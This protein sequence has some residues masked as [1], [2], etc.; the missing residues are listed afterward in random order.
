MHCTVSN[1]VRTP[2]TFGQVIL[3]IGHL[4]Y[5]S[6]AVGLAGVLGPATGCACVSNESTTIQAPIPAYLNVHDISSIFAR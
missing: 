1:Q 6:R 2:K 4:V 3:N 5:T